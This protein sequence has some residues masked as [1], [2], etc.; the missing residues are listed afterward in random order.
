[1]VIGIPRGGVAVGA[2]VARLRG[3]DLDV[4]VPRKVRAP[5]N[6][7][8][9]I[10]AIAPGVRL[11]DEGM[12][13]TLAVDPDYLVREVADQEREIARR[14]AAYRGDR[15]PLDL[16]GRTGIVIDDGVATGSTAVAAVR[17]VRAAG[18][19]R[20][21]VAVPVAPAEAVERLRREADGVVCL[22]TPARF[23]AV[24]EWYR[25]FP[26]VQDPEVVAHLDAA[27]S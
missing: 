23:H 2:E 18:A 8:L 25:R 13:A 4:V 1:V 6:P 3:W 15:P 5:Q 9:G 26:Q 7:E 11:L 17:S 22:I 14:L 16:A 21:V 12:I 10:G 27:W 19:R 24:G 20:V